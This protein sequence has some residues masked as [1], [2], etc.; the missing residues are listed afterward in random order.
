MERDPFLKYLGITLLAAAA[1]CGVWIF[2]AI[3]QLWNDP[4]NVPLLKYMGAF[5]QSSVTLQPLQNTV[6]WPSWLL[7][8]IAIFLCLMVISGMSFLTKA[9]LDAACM[10][11]VPEGLPVLKRIRA[12]LASLA[13][14]QDTRL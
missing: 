7:P 3:V 1:V 10:L 8:G 12:A 4:A 2:E 5:T 11:L 13:A 9:L 6:E 14:K